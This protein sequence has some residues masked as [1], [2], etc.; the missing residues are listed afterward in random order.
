M[1]VPNFCTSTDPQY[2]TAATC[3][4]DFVLQCCERGNQSRL[5]TNLRYAYIWC[6][7][8]LISH[9]SIDDGSFSYTSIAKQDDLELGITQTG[10]L[11]SFDSSFDFSHPLIINYISI[12]QTIKLKN[13]Q[14]VC[15]DIWKYSPLCFRKAA[16]LV[17]SSVIMPLQPIEIA[18]YQS[19]SS[20]TIQ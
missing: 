9:K 1:Q 15:S 3:R 17:G 13:N 14:K 18:L 12:L 2:P 4:C 19:Y 6:L 8:E 10:A 5:L 16:S 11:L 7:I 20:L